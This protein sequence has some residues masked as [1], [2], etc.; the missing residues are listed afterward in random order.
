MATGSRG[1]GHGGGYRR[2]GDG[3]SGHGAPDLA[4]E[5]AEA[6]QVGRQWLCSLVKN[7]QQKQRQFHGDAEGGAGEA[8]GAGE[9]AA[10][11]GPGGVAGAWASAPWLW[12]R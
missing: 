2:A 6:R 4:G 8:S 3:G 7:K 5:G 11:T 10:A 12:A 9:A 1:R